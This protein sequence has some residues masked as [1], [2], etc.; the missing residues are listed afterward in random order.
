MYSV[1]I[2][3]TEWNGL[4]NS[5]LYYKPNSTQRTIQV[6]MWEFAVHTHCH[7]VGHIYTHTHRH[8]GA[9]MGANV[10]I[11]TEE[12]REKPAAVCYP[13]FQYHDAVTPF[14][15]ELLLPC[16]RGGSVGLPIRTLH[17]HGYRNTIRIWTKYTLPL[18]TSA[19]GN[20][21]GKKKCVLCE[22]AN[23]RS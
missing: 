22:R 14:V 11:E 9:Q 20:A 1:C 19:N 2:L 7:G 12:R 21:N 10:W 17:T 6:L 23:T 16:A 18:H 5:R 3:Y 15:Y 8:T 13:I 4:P